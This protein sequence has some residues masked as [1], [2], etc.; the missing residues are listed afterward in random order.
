MAHINVTNDLAYKL[1]SVIFTDEGLAH[2][3]SQKKPS[4]IYL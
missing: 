1:L 2:M 3:V 4:K